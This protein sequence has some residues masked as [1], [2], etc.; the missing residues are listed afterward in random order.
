MKT[1][2]SLYN[3][4]RTTRACLRAL[5]NERLNIEVHDFGSADATVSVAKE[6]INVTEH[7]KLSPAD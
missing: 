5:M 2:V 6:L 1:I 7:G 3:V 4:E